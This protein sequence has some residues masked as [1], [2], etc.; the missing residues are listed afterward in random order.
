VRRAYFAFRFY[1]A[2]FNQRPTYAQFIPDMAK[3]GGPK[4]P[5]E[6][7]ASAA[8]FSEEFS[9]WLCTKVKNLRVS[10]KSSYAESV[11]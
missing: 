2:A 11:S 7:E 4:S 9:A 8:Q 3:V 1:M 6:Q 10:P 5:A